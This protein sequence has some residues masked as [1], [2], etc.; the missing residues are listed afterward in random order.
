MLALHAFQNFFENFEILDFSKFPWKFW[1]FGICAAPG[2][3]APPTSP[4]SLPYAAC[5][6]AARRGQERSGAAWSGQK[7][8]GT[9]RSGQERPGAAKNNKVAFVGNQIEN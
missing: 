7:R 8:T 3:S 9:P 5:L 4:A 1:N 2:S 6:G